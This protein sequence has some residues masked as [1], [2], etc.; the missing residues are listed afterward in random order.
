MSFLKSR[1]AGPYVLKAIR[2]ALALK[3][4]AICKDFKLFCKLVIFVKILFLILAIL[5]LYESVFPEY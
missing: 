2:E 5:I 1:N 4:T 3:N